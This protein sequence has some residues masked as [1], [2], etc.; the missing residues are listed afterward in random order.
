MSNTNNLLKLTRLHD[1]SWNGHV[2]LITILLDQKADIEAKDN[3]GNTLLHDASC[4]GHVELVT[5]LLDRKAEIEAKNDY[6]YTPLHYACSKGYVEV[7]TLLLDRKADIEAKN[8]IGSTPLHK[9]SLNG[10]V[11][12]VALLLDRKAD[13]EAKD[14]DGD[15]PLHF[16]SLTGHVKVVTR[17]LDRKADIEAKNKNG[18]TPLHF[19]CRN[20]HVKV[21]TRLLDRK[22]DIEAKDKYGSTPLHFAS[23][24][25]HVEVVTLLLDRKA[26]IEAKNN[27]GDTPL[28]CASSNGNVKVVTRLL[29]RKADIEAKN[30][31][32]DT[33]LHIA[34]QKGH[35]EVVTLLLDRQAYIEAKN[36]IG[37]TPLNCAHNNNHT[38]IYNIL[39]KKLN[40]HNETSPKLMPEFNLHTELF[41]I[42]LVG[43][44][45]S[46][47]SSLFNALAGG[48]IA[49]SSLQRETFRPEFCSFSR[50]A[51]EENIQIVSAKLEQAHK[52]NESNRKRIA[53]LTESDISTPV[54]ICENEMLLP[55]ILGPEKYNIY[56]FP[57]I[58]DAE[59]GDSKFYK[60]IKNNIS[61]ADVIFYVTDATRAFQQGSEVAQFKALQEL[62]DKENKNGH[63][64]EIKIIVNK[65]DSVHDEDLLDIYER[66]MEK[67]GVQRDSIFRCCSHK[68]M[69]ASIKANELNM[70]M[71]VHMRTEMQKIFKTADVIVT[72]RMKNKLIKDGY[73]SHNEIEYQSQID[74]E[75]LSDEKEKEIVIQK[76]EFKMTIKEEKVQL[77]EKNRSDGD[78]DNILKFIDVFEKNLGQSRIDLLTEKLTNILKCFKQSNMYQTIHNICDIEKKMVSKNISP[79]VFFADIIYNWFEL[80]MSDN[81]DIS[82]M[83]YSLYIY[84]RE[85]NPIY[86]EYMIRILEKSYEDKYYHKFIFYVLMCNNKQLSPK[87]MYKVFGSNIVWRH[88]NG[89]YYDVNDA[90]TKDIIVKNNANK[91]NVDTLSWIIRDIINLTNLDSIKKLLMLA[92]TPIKFLRVLDK[93]GLIPY[94]LV[95]EISPSHV[96]QLKYNILNLK[97]DEILLNNLF[98]IN[99][100]TMQYIA[101][102]GKFV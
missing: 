61:V 84:I 1:A 14:K 16:A 53:E 99:D 65:F 46:G 5:R 12:V 74:D 43:E 4:L 2:E 49:N 21:V 39:L 75:W 36:N 18:S 91:E 69:I 42:F 48:I 72:S 60:A 56:D 81:N 62:V 17:L 59:D 51:E 96:I 52:N 37:D 66:I 71:P 25:G 40:F 30:N 101:C 44:V 73:I 26:D 97:A 32:G 41:T 90:K 28:H 13:I 77:S 64:I 70:Y 7:V 79:S 98:V 50:T 80:I 8:N 55:A 35:V 34:C 6:G 95:E 63:F 15:T 89:N 45:S 47:K 3:T 100:D 20:G 19:A 87:L 11:E 58:N 82:R 38:E 68:M 27:N 67:V 24:K 9:A 54:T 78:W 93:E 86:D 57:G 94:N 23:Y 85:K 102:R 33:P 31:N 83:V 22:A 88:L 92:L 10:H 29:D 76:K